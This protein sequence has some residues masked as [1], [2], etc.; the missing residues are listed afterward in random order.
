MIGV[1]DDGCWYDCWEVLVIMM[2]YDVEWCGW[3]CILIWVTWMLILMTIV[4]GCEY[5]EDNVKNEHLDGFG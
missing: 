4:G 1:V 3:V 2:N 5:F